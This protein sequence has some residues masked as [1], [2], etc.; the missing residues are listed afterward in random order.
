[1]RISKVELVEMGI[2]GQRYDLESFKLTK[3]FIE[4]GDEE[5]GFEHGKR[6]EATLE[7][8]FE[9]RRCRA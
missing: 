8:S 6:L 7:V 3:A 4:M 5:K 9:R 1:M 2:D